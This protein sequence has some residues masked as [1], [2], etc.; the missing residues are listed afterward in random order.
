MHTTVARLPVELDLPR[1]LALLTPLVEVG[2]P[3]SEALN[4]DERRIL[5]R[6]VLKLA[7]LCGQL[8]LI[9]EKD[10]CKQPVLDPDTE[11]TPMDLAVAWFGLA[12]YCDTPEA[13]EL[14]K[15]VY[16]EGVIGSLYLTSAVLSLNLMQIA[17]GDKEKEVELCSLA[18]E[19]NVAIQLS[20]IQGRPAGETLADRLSDNI[21]ADQGMPTEEKLQYVKDVLGKHSALLIQVARL[22]MTSKPVERYNAQFGEVFSALTLFVQLFKDGKVSL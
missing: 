17:E 21:P 9:A 20:R 14:A 19:Y 1:V 13:R 8:V 15:R 11:I 18:L 2:E 22:S 12:C 4:S 3:A 16:V 10:G 5:T 6:L 7:I